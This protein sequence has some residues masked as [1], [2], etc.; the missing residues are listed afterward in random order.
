[1]KDHGGINQGTLM[2]NPHAGT[3]MW[4]LAWGGERVELG[5]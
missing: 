2:Y 1:M 5:E 4:G 3:T